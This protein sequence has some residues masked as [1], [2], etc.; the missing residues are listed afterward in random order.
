MPSPSKSARDLNGGVG[1]GVIVEVDV[2]VMV[3]V[4]VGVFVGVVVGSDVGVVVGSGD[5]VDDAVAVGVDVTGVAVAVDVA[6]AVSVGVDVGVA[7]GVPQS[8]P[9]VPTI[10]NMLSGGAPATQLGFTTQPL[11]PGHA[12]PPPG[13][14]NAAPLF[15]CTVRSLHPHSPYCVKFM[16]ACTDTQYVPSL[17]AQLDGRSMPNA[18]VDIPRAIGTLLNVHNAEVSGRVPAFR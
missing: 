14:R 1:D 17:S 4:A 9:V 11:A 18:P 7:V 10:W 3:A 5:A 2:G 6:V 16:F 8:P 15:D 13:L 12:K